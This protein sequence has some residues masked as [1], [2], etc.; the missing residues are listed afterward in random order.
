MQAK[1]VDLK[2]YKY[3][4]RMLNIVTGHKFAIILKLDDRGPS[5]Q[6]FSKLIPD[7]VSVNVMQVL[8]DCASFGNGG[9]CHS[10]CS[11][12]QFEA[13]HIPYQHLTVCPYLSV[14]VHEH[15]VIGHSQGFSHFVQVYI[16]CKWF[17]LCLC[18]DINSKKG[19]PV[20]IQSTAEKNKENS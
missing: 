14:C 16:V 13:I 18:N 17:Q 20:R 8:R 10:G 1:H 5:W 9:H 11:G 12:L 19:P 15:A 6:R 2:W 7:T 4:H 3:V